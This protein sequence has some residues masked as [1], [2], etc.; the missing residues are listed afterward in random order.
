MSTLESQVHA[1]SELSERTR[2]RMFAMLAA[3][4]DCVSRQRFFEDLS[5]K[6]EVILLSDL[7]LAEQRTTRGKC[8]PTSSRSRPG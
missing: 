7:L 1:V 6:D 2:D 3:N 5:W 8:L 4:Y